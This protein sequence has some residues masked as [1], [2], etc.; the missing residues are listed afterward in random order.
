MTRRTYLSVCL[1]LGVSVS[2][3]AQTSPQRVAFVLKNTLGYHRMFRVAGPGIAYGFTMNRNERT[4]QNWPIGSKL[5]FSDDG[6]T[7]GP[8]IL[9]VT[10][11]DAGKTLTT[12]VAVPPA[13][14]KRKFVRNADE[15]TVRFRNNSISFRK[16]ALI[17]YKPGEEGNGTSIFTMSPYA[18]TKRTFPVGTKV[19]F[20]DDQ[21]VSTVMNGD[22]IDTRKPFLV[23]K[24]SDAG[25]TYNIFN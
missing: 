2:L 14:V 3:F 13:G 21:Q 25:F 11:D 7:N 8:L 5:Y 23:V 24:R 19:Y 9:T 22:R 4:P 20:A 18:V 12:D 15:I 17:T 10:A 16:V 1:L 6:E